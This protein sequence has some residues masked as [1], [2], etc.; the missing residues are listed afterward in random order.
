[1]GACMWVSV[2]TLFH[3]TLQNDSIRWVLYYHR[4]KMRKLSH[5][6]P[7]VAWWASGGGGM[8]AHICL[9]V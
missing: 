5:R 2:Y 9:S 8:V 3:L 7:K 1:M 6:G 4:V